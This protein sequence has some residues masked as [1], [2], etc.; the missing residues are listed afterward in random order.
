MDYKA[1]LGME[2]R[3]GRVFKLWNQMAQVVPTL[4]S[5]TTIQPNKV[6]KVLGRVVGGGRSSNQVARV[7]INTPTKITTPIIRINLIK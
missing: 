3:T 1:D 7:V 2:V 4:L 6:L 5:L